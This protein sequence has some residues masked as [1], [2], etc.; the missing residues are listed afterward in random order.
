MLR[1][2]HNSTYFQLH[3]LTRCTRVATGE[4]RGELSGAV[5]LGSG[6]R[7]VNRAGTHPGPGIRTGCFDAGPSARHK[8]RAI[9]RER[10]RGGEN[11]GIWTSDSE[12]GG[13]SAHSRC[14]AR[15]DSG[16]EPSG[17]RAA[18]T[19]AAPVSPSATVC[20]RS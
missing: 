11:F 9:A 17:G 16:V 2:T 13:S 1:Y 20:S 18:A 4:C 15:A 14:G 7:G 3:C 19:P 12:Y 10:A 6:T 8:C 5:V